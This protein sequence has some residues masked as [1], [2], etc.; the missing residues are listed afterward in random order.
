[1]LPGTHKRRAL[2]T[3]LVTAPNAPKRVTCILCAVAAAIY[4]GHHGGCGSCS[5]VSPVA[6]AGAR[7]A[8]THRHTIFSQLYFL[9]SAAKEGSITPPRS[10]STK[11][12]VDSF[13]ML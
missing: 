6:A 12:R 3:P 10:R 5:W 2:N 13:W 7:S 8:R 4:R 11:C 1:M 9:A